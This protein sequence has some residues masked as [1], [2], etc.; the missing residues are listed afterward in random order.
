MPTAMTKDLFD[1]DWIKG[2]MESLTPLW[3][4]PPGSCKDGVANTV[5]FLAS[6]EASYLTGAAIPVD[7]A[8]T[9]L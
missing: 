3:N 1:S 2:R 5:A 6:S 4:A 7:G 9:A 8:Y